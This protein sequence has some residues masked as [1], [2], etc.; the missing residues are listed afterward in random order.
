MTIQNPP[1]KMSSNDNLESVQHQDEFRR[2][3]ERAVEDAQY[4]LMYASSNCP[5]DI[6]RSTLERLIIARLRLE[7]GEKLNAMEEAGFWLAYQDLWKLVRPVTAESVKANLGTENKSNRFL[8]KDILARWFGRESSSKARRT[9]NRYIVFSVIVL[10]CL[11]VLQIYWVIGNQLTTRAA[12]LAKQ[13]SGLSAELSN[14]EQE[15]NKLEIRYMQTEIDS[16]KYNGFYFNFYDSP[17]WKRDILEY[18]NLGAEL[19][20]NIELAKSQLGQNSDIL[21]AWSKPWR[22]LID[23]NV[24]PNKP[25]PHNDKY[26]PLFEDLAAQSTQVDD[27]L[28]QDPQGKNEAERQSS[29]VEAQAASIESQLNILFLQYNDL[30]DQEAAI[31][32]IIKNQ[33]VPLDA[34]LTAAMNRKADIQTKITNINDQLN[35]LTNDPAADQN[36]ISD[37]EAQLADYATQQVDTKKQIDAI[38]IK[39]QAPASEVNYQAQLDDIRT[40]KSAV[41][42]Q[43]QTL[44]TQS[45]Y[46]VVD[47]QAIADQYVAQLKAQQ[48]DL[49]SQESELKRQESADRIREESQQAQLAGQF[50]LVVLQSYLLPLLYGILGAS[51]S[52]LRTLSG[53]INSVTYSDEAG[54]QHLLRIALGALAGIVV[55][56]FSFLL[57]TDA[58]GFLGSVSP[59]AIAFLVGYNIELFFSTMDLAMNKVSQIQQRAA[60]PE[61]VQGTQAIVVQQESTYATAGAPSSGEEPVVEVNNDQSSEGVSATESSS[62]PPSETG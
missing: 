55:G 31:Q 34:Q 42:D 12:E 11:L 37:L 16:G 23:K 39:L 61:A 35:T 59:L 13:E 40:S 57:P 27:Q 20:T 43:I 17:E 50:V 44:Q 3:F 15:I 2:H 41:L 21:L 28:K 4:L 1:P 30:G 22:W 18:T 7:K 46:L 38:N 53:Q 48:A 47:K 26:A 58:A 5:N 6:K 49:T 56:W 54:I 60:A 25:I 19:E 24:D 51:T 36:K 45:Q 29:A 32:D 33:N 9:V 52:I 8:P 62:A 10:I 14:N